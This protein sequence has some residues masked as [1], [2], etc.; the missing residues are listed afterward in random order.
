MRLLFLVLILI[1]LA[2]VSYRNDKP[3]FTNY[4][5]RIEQ[6]EE[7]KRLMN[8]FDNT[9]KKNKDYM[10]VS[11]HIIKNRDG[12]EPKMM[13]VSLEMGNGMGGGDSQLL[14]N[15]IRDTLHKGNIMGLE[16]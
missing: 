15:S 2:G 3:N 14:K 11:I 10:R 6:Y 9:M 12:E 8:V 7:R 4:Q 16:Y 5:D 13:R 1:A